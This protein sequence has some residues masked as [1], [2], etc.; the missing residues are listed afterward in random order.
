MTALALRPSRLARL[1]AVLLDRAVGRIREARVTMA[2]EIGIVLYGLA[3][4]YQSVVQGGGYT[5]GW[6]ILGKGISQPAY[7]WLL[8]AECLLRLVALL[9]LSREWRYRLAWAD[10]LVQ[11]TTLY[12][13]RLA[14][15][16]SPMLAPLLVFGVLGNLW[17]IGADVWSRYERPR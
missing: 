8:A 11:G 3:S 1:L 9:F 6:A 14:N 5:R 13:V 7:G 10:L 15:P 12:A 17:A 16:T 2:L 4:V